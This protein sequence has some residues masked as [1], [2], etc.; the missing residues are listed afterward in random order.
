LK[1]R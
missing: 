1:A